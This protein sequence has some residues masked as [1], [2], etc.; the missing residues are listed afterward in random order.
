M[1][2]TPW[3]KKLIE[4][5]T[6][7]LG[8]FTGLERAL[9][10]PPGDEG[11]LDHLVEVVERDA[12]VDEDPTPDQRFRVEQGDLELVHARGFAGHVGPGSAPE[13]ERSWP[14][15]SAS[16]PENQGPSR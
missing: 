15:W 3:K 10:S 7:V 9:A 13:L 11:C 14:R 16:P 12:A 4:V 6:D 5:A 8:L 2:E 1:S